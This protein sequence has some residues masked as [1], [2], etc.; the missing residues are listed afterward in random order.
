MFKVFA[1][2]A[3]NDEDIRKRLIDT[4]RIVDSVVKAMKESDLGKVRFDNNL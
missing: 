2:L 3:A 1:S 4:Q